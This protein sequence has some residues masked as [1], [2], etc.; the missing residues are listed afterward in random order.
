MRWSNQVF[1]QGDFIDNVPTPNQA[2]YHAMTGTARM[3]HQ[4]LSCTRG[5]LMAGA[6]MGLIVRSGLYFTRHNSASTQALTPWI[7]NRFSE[8]GNEA[9]HFYGCRQGLDT[10]V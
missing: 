1:P 2:R 5:S 10:R 7:K 9:L 6:S 3:N 4:M 8:D